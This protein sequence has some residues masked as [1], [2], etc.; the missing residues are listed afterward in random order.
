MVFCEELLLN[1]MKAKSLLIGVLIG[2]VALPTIS[3]GG[4]FVSS[5][6]AGKTPS[7]AVEIL[8]T[9]IDNLFGRVGIVE[10]RQAEQE[11][12]ISGLRATTTQ[13]EQTISELEDKLAKEEACREADRLLIEIKETC[14][15]MPFPGIDECIHYR[16][17][18]L[19]DYDRPADWR[20]H[21]DKLKSLKSQYSI[22]NNQCGL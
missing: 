8:A 13:Q 19:R 10:T 11:E 20:Y 3:L 4:T 6:V 17:E 15:I 1:C 5:L 12:I 22:F 21:P 9:Q 2:A 7:E 18:E 16:E 14:G